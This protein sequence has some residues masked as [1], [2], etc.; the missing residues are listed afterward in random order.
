MPQG[1]TPHV[2]DA[3]LLAAW[4]KEACE[5]SGFPTD[6]LRSLDSAAVARQRASRG[7]L[8]DWLWEEVADCE[9]CELERYRHA[10]AYQDQMLT[11]LQQLRLHLGP[12]APE[13]R[14]LKLPHWC[15]Q[16]SDFDCIAGL[17]AEQP[18]NIAEHRALFR[19]K[20]QMVD[21][22]GSQ[23]DDI[24]EPKAKAYMTCRAVLATKIDFDAT[25][26]DRNAQFVGTCQHLLLVQ[27]NRSP[28]FQHQCAA[29]VGMKPLHR[30][31][32]DRRHV[33]AHILIRLCCFY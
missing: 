19:R 15:R 8:I 28:D 11:T 33:E 21:L 18:T 27:H 30:R 23:L 4:Q 2:G 10:Q 31:Q 14:S 7:S 12:D 32:T 25:P 6:Y 3:D 9:S 1:P 26:D 16:Q 29:A 13:L 20:A 17:L 24:E 22:V 5:T